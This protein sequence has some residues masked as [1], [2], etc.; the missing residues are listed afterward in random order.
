MAPMP[1]TKVCASVVVSNAEGLH[2]RPCSQLAELAQKFV[3][4]IKLICTSD[5][6]SREADAKSIMT[7]LTLG[8]Y[9]DTE[10]TIE[11][12]GTDAQEALEA[13]AGFITTMN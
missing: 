4:E 11:A 6:E 12:E 2:A 7:L 9:R 1:E 3:S 8:A 13:I 5:G 10:V